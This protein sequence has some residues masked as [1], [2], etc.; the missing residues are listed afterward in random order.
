M[1]LNPKICEKQ[2]NDYVSRLI[3]AAQADIDADYEGTP[4]Y[5]PLLFSNYENICKDKK[6]RGEGLK[7]RFSLL[8]ATKQF[9]TILFGKLLDEC[10]QITI[11]DKDEPA[12]I[13]QKLVDATTD[14]FSDFMIGMSDLHR[15]NFGPVLKSAGDPTRWFYNQI[16]GQLPLYAAK[17]LILA[18]INGIFDDFLK[19][20]AWDIGCLQWHMSGNVSEN[21]FLAVMAQNGMTSLLQ[22]LLEDSLREKAP[23]KPR[24]KKEKT[25]ESTDAAKTDG[26]ATADA[27]VDVVAADAKVDAADPE[28]AAMIG[29]I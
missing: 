24:S 22:S 25:P 26:S 12:A 3:Y 27:K 23:T 16:A 14:C 4:K 7:N 8:D 10:K 17:P 19:A 13:R 28:L 20:L 21:M 5:S 9:V 2:L 6:D 11:D 18:R 29:N 15:N 1:S